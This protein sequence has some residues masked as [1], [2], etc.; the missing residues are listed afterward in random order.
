MTD[1]LTPTGR[2]VLTLPYDRPP[3]SLTGN[4][5]SHWSRRTKDA[6]QLRD[7]IVTLGRQAGLREPC[8]HLWVTLRWSPGD[9][10]V[11]DED[12]LVAFQKVMVDA[13]AQSRPNW[14]SLRLVPD[15]TRT[16]V[17]RA[18]PVIEAPPYPTGMWLEIDYL[19][20]TT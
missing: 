13:L 5:R 18:M 11:R 15:D 4:S 20:T 16:Y 12:N 19:E 7:D 6:R 9:R 17:T 14:N 3:V 10:R 8:Q 2:V 1:T